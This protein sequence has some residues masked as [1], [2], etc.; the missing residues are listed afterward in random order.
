MTASLKAH[1]NGS[2]NSLP[3]FIGLNLFK[4]QKKI[5]KI[6]GFLLIIQMA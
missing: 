1:S 6:V 5:W 4:K 3:F 2:V